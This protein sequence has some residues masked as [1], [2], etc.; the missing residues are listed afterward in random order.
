MLL[1]QEVMQL[2]MFL[3]KAHRQNDRCSMPSFLSRSCVMT[4]FVF[5]Q[6][7]PGEDCALAGNHRFID[8]VWRTK[9]LKL[10]ILL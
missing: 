5:S 6:A 2:C 8:K 9:K 1:H 10:E 7:A 3:G 4:H